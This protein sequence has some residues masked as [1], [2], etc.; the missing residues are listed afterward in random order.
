MEEVMDIDVI[1]TVKIPDEYKTNTWVLPEYVPTAKRSEKIQNDIKK[2]VLPHATPTI[3]LKSS[4]YMRGRDRYLVK[5]T[6][7]DSGGVGDVYLAFD[8]VLGK[9]VV[10]KNNNFSRPELS[11]KKQTTEFEAKT[12]AHLL[13]D[14]RLI[15]YIPQVYDYIM[16]NDKSYIIMENLNQADYQRADT[17]I[18]NAFMTVK[19]IDALTGQL[20]K[21]LTIMGELGVLHGDIKPKNMMI[22]KD[23]HLKLIDFGMAQLN[24]AKENRINKN[25]IGTPGYIGHYSIAGENTTLDNT[26][27]VANFAYEALTGEP[28]LKED[29]KTDILDKMQ[30]IN[31]DRHSERFKKL[32]LRLFNS[33]IPIE[34]NDKIIDLFRQALEYPFKLNESERSQIDAQ[35]FASE[36]HKLLD[37]SPKKDQ[38]K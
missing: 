38:Q 17:I 25:L 15:P 19:Q 37:T 16:H 31:F 35:T 10:V 23:G 2:E 32:D 6:P 36:L 28:L 20:A 12:Q 9:E 26:F 24:I 3:D 33:G 5:D 27:H 13:K 14:P 21:A 18:D 7:L 22:S 8:T 29:N 34:T 30:D 1:D 11:D 4:E